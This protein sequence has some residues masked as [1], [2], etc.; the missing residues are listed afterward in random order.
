MLVAENYGT[1]SN[2]GVTG[3]LAVPQATVVGGLVGRNGGLI[4]SCY[5]DGL[6]TANWTATE[7]GPGGPPVVGGLVGANTGSIVCCYA[8]GM[9][10][11]HRDVGGLVGDNRQSYEKSGSITDC[12]ATT[13]VMAEF[14][15]GGL[16]AGNVGVITRCYAT[17]LVTGELRGG[18]VGLSGRSSGTVIGCLWDTFQTNCS[19]S[20]GGLGLSDAEMIWPKVYADNGW[21]GDP[22]WI[23]DD[24]WMHGGYHYPR[25]SW[26]GI[27]G[28]PVPEPVV[29]YRLTGSGTQE[30]PYQIATH[31]DLEWLTT[32][33]IFWDKHF[34]LVKD[35]PYGTAR[36]IGISRGSAFSGTFDGNGHTIRSV[37]IDTDKS[38]A[39]NLGVFG[40]VTGQIRNLTVEDVR[41][42]SGPSTRCAGLLAGTCEGGLIENCHVSGSV[43]VGE[44]SQYIGQLVGYVGYRGGK[45]VD[46]EANATIDAGEGSTDVGGLIGYQEPDTRRR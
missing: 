36:T 8:T 28:T 30:D 16:A 42:A 21:A 38:P 6:I 35:I 24:N 13:V 12:Y 7:L 37:Y 45:V 27:E 40:Y 25:L 39:W 29:P 34:V 5:F 9:A 44:N 46:C 22:N 14:G 43:T 26:E 15:G 33:S 4:R 18:L 31:D 19:T 1:I 32:A 20:S 11:G 23:I 17:G 10:I 3:W 2:C 41:L